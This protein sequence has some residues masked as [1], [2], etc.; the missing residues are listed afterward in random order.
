MKIHCNDW[1]KMSNSLKTKYDSIFREVDTTEPGTD[2][3]LLTL[4]HSTPVISSKRLQSDCPF[5]CL[6]WMKIHSTRLLTRQRNCLY[7][8]I[9]HTHIPASAPMSTTVALP[10]KPSGPSLSA[11]SSRLHKTACCSLPLPGLMVP[12]AGNLL[13]TFAFHLE[14]KSLFARKIPSL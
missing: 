6:A 1:F 2:C 12:G 7:I 8:C 14:C 11:D 9:C 10:T 13:V 5:S 4:P 3:S